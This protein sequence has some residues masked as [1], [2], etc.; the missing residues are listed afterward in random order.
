V[1]T[2]IAMHWRAHGPLLFLRQKG[3]V[4][5]IPFSRISADADVITFSL[6][7]WR[8]AFKEVD[9][10]KIAAVENLTGVGGRPYLLFRT[11]DGCLREIA[12]GSLVG[13]RR[14]R[15]LGWPISNRALSLREAVAEV[16]AA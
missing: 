15:E 1:L 12:F 8:R 13:V 2:G 10:N 5:F 16:C 6:P 3:L 14:L 9:R 7:F 11:T 4:P